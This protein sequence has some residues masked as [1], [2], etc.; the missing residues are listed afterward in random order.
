[1]YSLFIIVATDGCQDQ[2]AGLTGRAYTTKCVLV[3]WSVARQRDNIVTGRFYK[4]E[5]YCYFTN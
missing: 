4:S 5:Q 2:I 1:M 3:N